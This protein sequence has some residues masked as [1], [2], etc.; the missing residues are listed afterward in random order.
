MCTAVHWQDYRG[1]GNWRNCSFRKWENVKGE[2]AST[3]MGNQTFSRRSTSMT[4]RWL[5]REETLVPMWA[6]LRKTIDFEGSTPPID[7][8]YLGCTQRA[9]TVAEETT[10]TNTDMF[11]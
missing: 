9:A 1:N 11:R 4:S 6:T 5:G 8:V 2:N 3:L 7:Q 10:S